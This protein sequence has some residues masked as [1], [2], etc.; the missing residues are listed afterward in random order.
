M[1][2]PDPGAKLAY[3]EKWVDPIALDILAKHP[4]IQVLRLD[5][6]APVEISLARMQEAAGYQIAPRGELREPWFGNG[7]LLRCCPHLLAIT[8][9]GSGYDMVDVEACTRAGVIVCNQTGSNSI[10]V[11]E[12]ALGLTLALLHKFGISDRAMRKY[13]GIDRFD[14]AGT[15]ANGKTIGLV[16]IGQIGTRMAAF[17]KALGMTVLAYDPHLTSAEISARGAAPTDWEQLLAS[18][19]VISVHCPRTEETFGMLNATAFAQMKPGAYFVSTA[20]GGIHD[21]KDLHFALAS[22]HLAGAGLDVFLQEPPSKAHPLLSLDNVIATPH[23][24]GLSREAVRAMASYAAQQWV[25]IFTG[26]VPPRLVN[27]EA[28]PLYSA[29]FSRQFGFAPDEL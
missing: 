9:T 22:G 10:A 20:R 29:K 16:G 3:F 4:S 15:D 21:E 5:Y 24:A 26:R 17:C 28:W 27:P 7:D 25:D 6:D 8:S 11:A 18:S 23:S 12:H 2:N 14:Y 19:D 1:Q 13:E